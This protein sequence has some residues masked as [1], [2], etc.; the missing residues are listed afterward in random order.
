MLEVFSG[1]YQHLLVLKGVNLGLIGTDDLAM[2]ASR[3]KVPEERIEEL[4]A[5][6]REQGLA[7]LPEEEKAALLCQKAEDSGKAPQQISYERIDEILSGVL[8]ANLDDTL[9]QQWLIRVYNLHNSP[10]RTVAF[11]KIAGMNAEAIVAQLN[12]SAEELYWYEC[13]LLRHYR[14][15]LRALTHRR[16]SRRGSIADFYK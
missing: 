7:I 8:A 12:I 6:L 11:M 3:F 4:T 9:R 2:M 14:M 10:M 5:Y 13:K 16:A 1:V 15:T